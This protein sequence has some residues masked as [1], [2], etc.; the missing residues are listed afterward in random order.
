MI[1]LKGKSKSKHLTQ[2]IF[3]HDQRYEPPQIFEVEENHDLPEE[4]QD[5]ETEVT[6][7]YEMAEDLKF[8]AQVMRMDHRRVFEI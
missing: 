7:T 3:S 5:F 2:D 8:R 1:F 6:Q 4:S